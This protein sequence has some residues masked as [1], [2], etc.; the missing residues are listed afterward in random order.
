MMAS[1][2]TTTPDIR[3]FVSDV[4][5]GGCGGIINNSNV[6][7]NWDGLCVFSFTLGVVNFDLDP[8]SL[9]QVTV[10]L[11]GTYPSPINQS[12]S[13]G[14]DLPV[15]LAPHRFWSWDFSCPYGT[16]RVS[17]LLTVDG[18]VIDYGKLT[19]SD[20]GFDPRYMT[21][22][23]G[24]YSYSL[25]KSNFFP[26]FSLLLPIVGLIILYRFKNQK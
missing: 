20:S 12:I 9:D 1:D 5:Q 18:R 14:D 7:T 17:A 16:W 23:P 8:H 19:P 13:A 3:L 6:I 21:S 2:I 24:I 4:E 10:F 11:R 26:S 22:W 15:L 25:S